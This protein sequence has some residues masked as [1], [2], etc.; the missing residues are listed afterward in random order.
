MLAIALED[1]L[2]ALTFGGTAV[3]TWTLLGLGFSDAADAFVF[4]SGFVF[5]FKH[6]YPQDW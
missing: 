1:H 3:R 5:G 2:D 4:I 6:E